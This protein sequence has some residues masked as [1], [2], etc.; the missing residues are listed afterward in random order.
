MTREEAIDELSVLWE[1]F[2]N[3][4]G[5]RDGQY[6]QALDMAIEAL[7]EQSIV[8]C[9]ECKHNWN[10]ARNH[11]VM[12]PRCDFT[13]KVLSENDFCSFGERREP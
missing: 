10:T 8:R 5:W 1:R 4:M 7:S 3:G 12:N 6:E 2:H 13:K 9:G 11:G